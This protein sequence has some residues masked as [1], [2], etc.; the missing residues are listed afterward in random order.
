MTGAE[1]YDCDET[2]APHEVSGRHFCET[3]LH[4]RGLRAGSTGVTNAG[5]EAAARLDDF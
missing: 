2:P 1:C 5:A 4:A 3:C